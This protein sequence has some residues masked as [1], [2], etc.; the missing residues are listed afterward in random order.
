MAAATP[1]PEP[2]VEAVVDEVGDDEEVDDDEELLELP[3]ALRAVAATT[4]RTRN[5]ER[6]RIMP[7]LSRKRPQTGRTARWAGPVQHVAS[8][9]ERLPVRDHARAEEAPCDRRGP[10]LLPRLRRRQG[11]SRSGRHL[12]DARD[13]RVKTYSGGIKRRLDL[14]ISMIERPQVL[15]LDEPTTGLDPPSRERLWSTVRGLVA[16]GVSVLLTTQYLEEA[17]QLADAVA[18]LGHGRIVAR[19]EPETV[20]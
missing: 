7:R 20:T 16:Q 9:E 4:S 2:A 5:G 10:T 13:R 3:H 8:G 14:A 6:R 18:M 17:D 1:L 12:I 15:F 11:Q 19:G